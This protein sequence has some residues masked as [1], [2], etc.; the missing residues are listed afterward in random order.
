MFAYTWLHAVKHLSGNTEIKFHAYQPYPD[1]LP[2]Q[3]ACLLLPQPNMALQ[4]TETN[5]Q[6]STLP[7]SCQLSLIFLSSCQH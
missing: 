3:T 1:S 7:L 4:A 5:T 6:F 2:N